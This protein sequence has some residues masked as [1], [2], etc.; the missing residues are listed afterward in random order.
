MSQV[1]ADCEC[2]AVALHEGGGPQ[3]AAIPIVATRDP[4]TRHRGK[5]NRVKELRY[6]FMVSPAADPVAYCN[7]LRNVQPVLQ[8]DRSRAPRP[9]DS[10]D[11]SSAEDPSQPR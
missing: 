1:L 10:P 5:A 11:V 9:S 7:G 6:A 2:V 3:L 8:P 4:E